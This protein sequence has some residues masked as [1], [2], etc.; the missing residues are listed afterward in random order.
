MAQGLQEVIAVQQKSFAPNTVRRQDAAL[1]EFSNWLAEYGEDSTPL[2]CTPEQVLVYIH[3]YWIPRHSPNG[4]AIAPTTVLNQLSHLSTQFRLLGRGMSY[5][6]LACEGNPCRSVDM[7]LY[8]KGFSRGAVAEGF[9]EQ[10]AVPLTHEKFQT[11]IRYLWQRARLAAAVEQL[12]LLRDLVCFVIMWVTTSRGHDCGKLRLDDFRDPANPRR[13]YGGFPLPLSLVYPVGFHLVMSQLG[14]KTYQGCRAPPVQ[15][16]PVG[17]LELCPIR[18]LAEYS[19]VCLLPGAPAGSAI[20]NYLFRP[21]RSDHAGFKESA[22]SSSGLTYRLRQHLQSAGLYDGETCHSF[23]RGALQHAQAAGLDEASLMALGQM[24]S[25]GT[26]KRY[27]DPTRHE[28]PDGPV[29]R[30]V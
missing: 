22:M 20:T 2:D 4:K 10:S 25:A 1:E 17:D 29:R 16:W 27:L 5:D 18:A 24:R 9:L 26:L 28:D 14:T 7:S 12:L 3:R 30:R 11:L 19:R 13:P 6:E 15:L 23:R 21:L 8:R